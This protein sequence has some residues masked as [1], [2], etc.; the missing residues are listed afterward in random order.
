M[1]VSYLENDWKSP[2]F[3]E[4]KKRTVYSV[5]WTDFQ[6]LSEPKRFSFRVENMC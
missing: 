6:I 5:L 3:V 2:E 4:K 1:V